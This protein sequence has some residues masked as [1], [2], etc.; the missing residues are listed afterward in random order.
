MLVR[1]AATRIVPARYR[2]A[3][4]RRSVTSGSAKGALGLSLRLGGF[5][6]LLT[7]P[8]ALAHYDERVDSV[9]GYGVAGTAAALVMSVRGGAMSVGW[10]LPLGAALGSIYGVLRGEARKLEERLEEEKRKEALKD[11]TP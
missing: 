8:D 10:A 3:I 4:M 9:A 7:A 1:E 5:V 11:S 6:A 2:E